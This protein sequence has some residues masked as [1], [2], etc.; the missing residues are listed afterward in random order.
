MYACAEL[1]CALTNV[2]NKFVFRRFPLR[3]GSSPPLRVP[4]STCDAAGQISIFDK[5]EN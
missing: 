2:S 5:I 4:L 3:W 1:F